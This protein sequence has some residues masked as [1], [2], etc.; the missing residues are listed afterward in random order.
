[1]VSVTK[2]PIKTQGSGVSYAN[3]LLIR[4]SRES[5]S[6]NRNHEIQQ[7]WYDTFLYHIHALI[8]QPNK[9]HTSDSLAVGDI[10]LFTHTE[11]SLGNS[12]WKIGRVVS[13]PD[14]SKVVI[15][16]PSNKEYGE[17]GLNKLSTLVRSPHNISV[18]HRVE[19]LDLNSNAYH[20]SLHI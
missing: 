12:G 9:W 11:S 20:Q 7:F 8:P 17:H 5:P 3:H 2:E 1:M 10:V 13:I 18:I 6:E 4:R 16:Y 19:E 14:K 15:E